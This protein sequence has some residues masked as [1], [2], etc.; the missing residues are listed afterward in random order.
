M[1]TILSKN[2]KELSYLILRISLLI[3]L[4]SECERRH[5]LTLSNEGVEEEETILL[6]EDFEELEVIVEWTRTMGRFGNRLEGCSEEVGM[7]ISAKY[8]CLF[9][10]PQ[11]HCESL[12]L[13]FVTFQEKNI[14]A[15]VWVRILHAKT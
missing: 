8:Q 14:R 9:F 12:W 3:S 2:V 15:S 10:F 7:D 6:P 4:I 11:S 5:K 13:F 1:R